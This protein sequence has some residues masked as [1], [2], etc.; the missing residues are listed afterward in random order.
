MSEE[1]LQEETPEEAMEPGTNICQETPEVPTP[2][3][4]QVRRNHMS[5]NSGLVLSLRAFFFKLE[6]YVY[7]TTY[8]ISFN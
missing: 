2:E 4:C 7:I 5:L 6:V 3:L 1:H 8:C